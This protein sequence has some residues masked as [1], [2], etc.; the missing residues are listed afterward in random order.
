MNCI[1]EIPERNNNLFFDLSRI[2]KYQP[3]AFV[4][5]KFTCNKFF[6]MCDNFY[7]LCIIPFFRFKGIKFNNITDLMCI[8]SGV[9]NIIKFIFIIFRFNLYDRSAVFSK[10]NFTC[11]IFFFNVCSFF[12]FVTTYL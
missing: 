5:F 10:I 8:S 9:F 1:I 6:N 7:N 12:E 3:V 4:I 2:G 11:D